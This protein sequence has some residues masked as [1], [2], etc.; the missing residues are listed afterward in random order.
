MPVAA[1]VGGILGKFTSGVVIFEF[2]LLVS[3]L[4]CGTELSLGAIFFTLFSFL[5]KGDGELSK[6][7]TF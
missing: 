6:I 1:L 7:P 5:A 2:R 4:E 3:F